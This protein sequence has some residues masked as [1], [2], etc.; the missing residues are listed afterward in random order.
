MLK[1]G[2]TIT[3][4][5]DLKLVENEVI[6]K[7][8]CTDSEIRIITD[9]HDI[10]FYHEQDCCENVYIELMSPLKILNG[11][12]LS[13]EI[14]EMN[15]KYNAGGHATSTWLKIATTYGYFTA[16][17]RGESNGYYSESVDFII[18]PCASNK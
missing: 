10:F 16:I 15:E 9:K 7:V 1:M 14:V 2:N 4:Y 13:C 12:I 3:G 11:R 8:E 6:I 5:N 18:I 17:W